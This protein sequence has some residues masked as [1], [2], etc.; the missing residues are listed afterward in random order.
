[1][2]CLPSVLKSIHYAI[3]YC[4]WVLLFVKKQNADRVFLFI[5]LD[6]KIHTFFS[7]F[8]VKWDFYKI[9]GLLENVR[10]LDDNVYKIQ[11]SCFWPWLCHMKS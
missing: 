8:R 7:V 5:G 4:S 9:A 1:M 2:W 3:F 6:T 10:T 11:F